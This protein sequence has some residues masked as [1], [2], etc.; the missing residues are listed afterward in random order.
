LAAACTAVD[1]SSNESW[2]EL[3]S[4]LEEADDG[5]NARLDSASSIVPTGR[6]GA[7]HA[8]EADA[9]IAQ[10]YTT[11]AG[12]DTEERPRS[13]HWCL[14]VRRVLIVGPPGP[15]AVHTPEIGTGSRNYELAAGPSEVRLSIQ[16]KGNP[17]ETHQ[18]RAVRFKRTDID[19]T[20]RAEAGGRLKFAGSPCLYRLQVSS[21]IVA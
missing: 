15:V 2:F 21:W 13:F 11:V 14:T 5:L 3:A 10:V 7:A 20:W 1:T 12:Q 18:F 19:G 6:F 17:A 9:G 16:E 8:L 4:Q